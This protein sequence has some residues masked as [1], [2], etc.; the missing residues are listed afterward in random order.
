M[1]SEEFF[2]RAQRSIVGGVNSPVR[3]FRAVGGNPPFI[4]R[5]S[6]AYLYTEDGKKYLDYV[7]SWGASIIGHAHPQVIQAIQG[8]AADGLSFGAPTEIETQ[9][10]E[11]IIKLMPGIAQLRMVNSGT[12]ATMTA[13]RLARGYTRRDKIIKFN[14]CYHGH[15][16]P[17]LVKAGSGGLTLG[18]PDSA[19]V[20]T[21]TAADTLVAEFND[22]SSVETLFAQH[23]ETIAAVIIEPIAGNM[24]FVP[25]LS[26]FLWGLRN[27]CDHYASVL[28]FDEVM[29]GFRVSLGG[30]QQHYGIAPDLTCLGKVIGGG[31]P[32]GAVGGKREIMQH[33]APLG[34]VYQAGTLSGNPLAMAAGLAAL[35]M[36]QQDNFYLHLQRYTQ[37]LTSGLMQCAH[38][39]GVPLYAAGL[40]GMFGFFFTEEPEIRTFGQLKNCDLSRFQRF[41]QAMLQQNIYFAPS[42]FEAGFISAAHDDAAL[43]R[44][45]EAARIAF[46]S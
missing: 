17:L 39:T 33:L 36:L 1:A 8:R 11:T 26:E 2:S 3:A 40:G 20:P 14:G 10:A 34:K 18:V 22:I 28:I 4:Q 7:C 44:T 45:L 23:G 9:L 24:N 32:V 43:E 29:S 30:A 31:M 15:A 16:D 41:F 42:A 37:K 19:G 38:E 21:Q 25:A 46:S 12:E 5:A 13:I 27:L 35:E 6:G